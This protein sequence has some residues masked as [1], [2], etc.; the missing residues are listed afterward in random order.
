MEEPQEGGKQ[1]GCVNTVGRASCSGPDAMSRGEGTVRAGSHVSGK[2]YLLIPSPR[3][4]LQHVPILQLPWFLGS[5]PLSP[6][7]PDPVLMLLV[8]GKKLRSRI[9][10]L[11]ERRPRVLLHFPPL[12]PPWFLLFSFGSPPQPRAESKL[13]ASPTETFISL[14]PPPSPAAQPQ[15]HTS[16][17]STS[18]TSK[19]VP[20]GKAWPINLVGDLFGAHRDL[21]VS[22]LPP[23][24]DT[25]TAAHNN[26]R[27]TLTSRERGETSGSAQCSS[28]QTNLSSIQFL[29]QL[30]SNAPV[31][32][33]LP[34]QY[35]E[36]QIFLPHSRKLHLQSDVPR[37]GGT[38]DE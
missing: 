19:H 26:S 3:G 10:P 18:P 28:T 35:K 23:T 16:S 8:E 21:N 30:C 27:R 29:L 37:A 1:G 34:P 11:W 22:L 9:P 14:P 24:T 12:Q 31:L 5:L 25:T 36:D 4:V 17:S 13:N 38:G 6:P 7:Q 20:A 33:A 2:G 15:Q 32:A